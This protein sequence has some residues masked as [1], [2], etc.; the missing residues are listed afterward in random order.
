MYHCTSACR[1]E[2][3]PTSGC[4]F[5]D[6]A[7]FRRELQEVTMIGQTISHYKILEKLGEG[8][9]GVVYKAQDTKLDRLVALKFLP[10]HISVGSAD[11]ERFIQEAK[12][13]SALNHPN[14]LTIY[15]FIED[16]EQSFIAMELVEGESLKTKVVEAKEKGSRLPISQVLDYAYQIA[17]GL[18][19]AH[20]KG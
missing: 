5:E 18:F 7:V 11:L 15:D 19:K 16:Q 10:E 8:G 12:A 9:M 2:C 14:I 6:P 3:F 20:E 13:A 17:Q 4:S 1:H